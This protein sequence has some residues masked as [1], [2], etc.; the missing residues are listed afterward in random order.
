VAVPPDQ[1]GYQVRCP[2]GELTDVHHE[3]GQA[4]AGT[5]GQHLTAQGIHWQHGWFPEGGDR[6]THYFQPQAVTKRTLMHNL[7]QRFP[8]VRYVVCVGDNVNDD[9]LEEV[10]SGPAQVYSILAGDHHARLPELLSHPR[11]LRGEPG[12]IGRQLNQHLDA[13]EAAL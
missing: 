4:L 5:V 12:R 3:Y 8:G 6:F 7:V 9:H 2:D 13:I 1:A 11:L 10:E